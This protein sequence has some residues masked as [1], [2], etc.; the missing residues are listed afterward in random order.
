[1]SRL[2]LQHR[3]PGGWMTV[4][5]LDTVGEV[6]WL[7]SLGQVELRVVDEYDNILDADANPTG[8]KVEPSGTSLTNGSSV[9]RSGFTKAHFETAMDMSAI[10]TAAMRTDVEYDPVLARLQD[11]RIIRLLHA[12]IGMATEAGELLDILK[13]HLFYGAPLD[14]VNALEEIGDTSWYQRLG[15]AALDTTFLSTMLQNVR[16]LRH[17]YPDKFTEEKALNRD[18]AGERSVLE[19]GK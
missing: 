1:M 15:C 11:V 16:K 17:R 4:A 14:T 6:D 19:D 13:K 12:A 3:F 5:C 8:I 7:S 9:E 18:L 2:K 10:E